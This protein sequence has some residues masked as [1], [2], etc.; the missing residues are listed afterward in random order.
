[1]GSDGGA[2][3][4]PRRQQ[5]RQ[6]LMMASRCPPWR[7]C[8]AWQGVAPRL[9]PRP[10]RQGRQSLP[11]GQ[12]QLQR[13]QQRPLARDLVSGQVGACRRLG[14]CVISLAYA[15]VA[16][17]AASGQHSPCLTP[18]PPILLPPGRRAIRPARQQGAGLAA[19]GAPLAHGAAPA[20]PAREAAPQRPACV[21]VSHWGSTS[22]GYT[23]SGSCPCRD[24]NERLPQ[25]PDS[26]VAHPMCAFTC[27]MCPT[28][29]REVRPGPC[30][31]AGHCAA[32]L[33]ARAAHVVQG[34]PP[35]ARPRRAGHS[36]HAVHHLP[37][38]QVRL[39][40]GRGQL[41]GRQLWSCFQPAEAGCYGC[42]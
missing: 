5:G 20:G 13:Q 18:R 41:L 23:A 26:L 21:S 6:I 3:C 42:K 15:C 10:P 9:A 38:V 7:R 22:V 32:R 2:C 36:L 27:P 4:W 28:L 25:H 17:L 14:I 37:L 29:Q 40:M 19:A 34:H 1:M 24:C 39:M 16:F 30:V 11:A 35:Q 33:A 8:R 31:Q 12:L